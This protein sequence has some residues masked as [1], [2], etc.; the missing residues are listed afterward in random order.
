MREKILL[1]LL[2]RIFKWTLILLA[3]TC[4][5]RWHNKEV[6]EKY[7]QGTESCLIS[8]WHENVLIIPWLMRNQGVAAMV[9]DS[10]DGEYIARTGQA[11]GNKVIRGSS[12]KGATKA[13]RAAL[14]WLKQEKPMGITPDGPRG[15]AH[16]LQSGVLWLSALAERPIVPLHIEVNRHWR[17][18]SW[19]GQKLPKPFSTIHVSVGDPI[20]ITKQQLEEDAVG[21]TAFVQSQ[22]M[23]N[24]NI[25]RVNAGYPA[26]KDETA[27]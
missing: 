24:T 16:K 6:I 21:I 17:A 19:D 8:F 13:T 26:I 3:S 14:R 10:R 25:A 1:Y 9:S 15:P 23:R 12:S 2:P 20:Q 7:T 5:V 4:R 18:K 22:M 11:F 27:E